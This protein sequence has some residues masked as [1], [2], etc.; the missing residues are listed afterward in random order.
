MLILTNSVYIL[1]GLH[2]NNYVNGTI[3]MYDQH[4]DS[5]CFVNTLSTPVYAQGFVSI[6]K[7]I[8][9]CV[10]VCV[11]VMVLYL[12]HV[13]HGHVSRRQFLVEVLE[14]IDM[15]QYPSTSVRTH[16]HAP[17]HHSQNRCHAY[18]KFLMLPGAWKKWSFDILNGRLPQSQQ[19]PYSSINST[20]HVDYPDYSTHDSW[21][22][23][24]SWMVWNVVECAILHSALFCYIIS[25]SAIYRP[26]TYVSVQDVASPYIF[27]F[28]HKFSMQL[29]CFLS[30]AV[31]ILWCSTAMIICHLH[32][33]IT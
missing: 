12:I 4:N 33:A 1:G 15:H 14:T 5:W 28:E 20:R 13:Q 32:Q 23:I 10:S 22:P 3:E 9:W 11:C 19:K 26:A 8:K 24:M 16:T 2:G 17:S 25:A 18:D 7:D 30:F 27:C 21:Y 31:F 29:S 6:F